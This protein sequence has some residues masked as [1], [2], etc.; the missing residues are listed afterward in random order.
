VSLS[1]AVAALLGVSTYQK[2]APVGAAFDLS[3]P[4]VERLRALYGGQLSLQPQ[5]RTRWYLEDLEAAEILSDNGNLSTAAQLMRSARKDGILAGVLSTRTD[6][7]VRL[8]K[9]LRGDSEIVGELE[10]QEDGRSV[11][12]DMFPPQELALLAADGLLLG[13]GVGELLPVEGRD[14]PVFQRLDP[15]GL[16]FR[17]AENRWY[18][19]T[20]AGEIPITPG[21]GR[22]VLHCPGGRNAPWQNGLWKCVG[23]N[24]IRK[25]H[26]Q[27][28]KDNWEAKLANPARVAVAPSG[29]TEKDHDAW[30]QKVMA[31]GINTVFG[32]KPGWDVKI[33]ESNG[34]GAESFRNTTKDCNEEFIVA[35]AGQ[36]V[37]TDGGTGFANADVHKSIRA[38]LIKS[39]ADALAHTLN[40]QGRRRS[41]GPPRCRGTCAPR[42]T[43]WPRPRP[44][45]RW[46]RPSPKWWTP[47]RR[48]KLAR[49]W[50]WPRSAASTESRSWR[51]WTGMGYQTRARGRRHGSGWWGE[52]E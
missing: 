33:L 8:P 13:V 41:A 2:A 49:A 24:Y 38:D 42:G 1:S 12:E 18:Y 34:R 40:T 39:T 32:L 4:E 6:G 20:I 28:H 48:R 50:T 35:V 52:H 25:E 17:W 27:L 14:F 5:S 45:S 16:R 37:T 11:F 51:T 21:D 23:K 10:G 26:A 29:A 47:W 31:W 46:P 36:T 9:R 22:W 15:A 19:A 43:W 30:F 7:L 44:C 3:S